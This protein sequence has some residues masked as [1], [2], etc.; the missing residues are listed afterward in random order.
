MMSDSNPR[1]RGGFWWSLL[2]ILIIGAG[3]LALGAPFLAGLAATVAVAWLLVFGGG[4]HFWLAFEPHRWGSR[5]WHVL[6]AIAY[7]FGGGALFFEPHLGLISLTLFLSVV[8]LV[9][10][11]FRIVSWFAVARRSGALWL[12]ADGIVTMI[13]GGLVYAAWPESSHW[14]IGT[15]VGVALLWNGFANLMFSIAAHRTSHQTDNPS[16]HVEVPGRNA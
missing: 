1:P 4:L 6:A 7:A 13:V 3:V 5:L 2:S 9:S 14:A 16:G 11:L 12:L 15:L 10:G 8:L